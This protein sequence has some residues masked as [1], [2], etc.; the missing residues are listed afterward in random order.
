M[1][2]CANAWKY[3]I[4]VVMETKVNVRFSSGSVILKNLRNGPA[5][6]I[7]AGLII[8]RG[9]ALDARDEEDDIVADIRPQREHDQRGHE[10]RG[11]PAS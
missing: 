2:N 8:A 3:E 10:V 7:S 1:E 4:T 5:P 11:S 6:S 9:N